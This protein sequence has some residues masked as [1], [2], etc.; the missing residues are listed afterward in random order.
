MS[1][2]NQHDDI[3]HNVNLDAD[4]GSKINIRRQ[5]I[6]VDMLSSMR[7]NAWNDISGG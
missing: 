2:A 7:Q 6:Q 4:N 1:T 5:S 3:D